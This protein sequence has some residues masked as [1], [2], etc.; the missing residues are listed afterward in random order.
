[1]STLKKGHRKVTESGLGFEKGCHKKKPAER[2]EA[3]LALVVSSVVDVKYFVA[4]TA[5][6]NVSGSEGPSAPL[7][8]GV[9]QSPHLQLSGTDHWGADFYMRREALTP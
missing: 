7:A 1:M 9:T 4:V 8:G 3:P 2:S 5:D 6:Q